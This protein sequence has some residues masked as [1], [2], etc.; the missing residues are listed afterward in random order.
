MKT[1]E[2]VLQQAVIE[3]SEGFWPPPQAGNAIKNSIAFDGNPV[4]QICATYAIGAL[5]KTTSKRCG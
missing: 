1:I 5:Q 4:L 2:K 3:L